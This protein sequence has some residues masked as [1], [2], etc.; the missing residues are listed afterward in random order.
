LGSLGGVPLRKANISLNRQ[1]SGPLAPGTRTNYSVSTDPSGRFAFTGIEPGTYRLSASHTGYLDTSYNARRPGGN[2]TPLDL[3]KAQRMTNVILKLTPQGL[4][5]GK[6]TDEDGDPLENVQVEVL[7]YTY[8]TGRK[9]LQ[10]VGSESTNDAGE[11]RISRLNPDKYF[12]CAVYRNRR[13][14]Q[15][16]GDQPQEDYATTYYPGGGDIATASPVEV[17]PGDQIQGMTMRLTKNRMVR[18]RGRAV[19]NTVAPSRPQANAPTPSPAAPAS[20]EELG[21]RMAE[22]G[23]AMADVGAQMGGSDV[24]VRLVPR[25]S[26]IANQQN[27]NAAVKADGTFEFGS[28]PSGSYDLIAISN[29][30]NRGRAAKQQLDVGSSNIEGINISINPGPSV[31]GRIH[32]EGDTPPDSLPKMTVRFTSRE[33]VSGIQAVP[34]ATVAAD[35]T[36]RLDDVNPDHYSVAINAPQGYYVKSMRAGNVDVLVSGMDLSAGAGNLVI[37][38]GSNPPQVGGSVVNSDAAQ[39]APAVTV[40]LIP[41][42]KER[43]GQ[44]YFYSSTTSDQYGNFTF[45]RVSPGEYRAFAWEDVTSG[46]WYDPEFMKNYDGK[47]EPVSAKEAS[48]VTLKLTMIP[49][50]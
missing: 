11:F 32:F 39:P 22:L 49:A 8:N 37:E 16:A 10:R 7:R 46:S 31:A 30:G 20:Q 42:E 43:Q 2:G 27:L 14:A 28:V 34:P 44:S 17:G 41:Q 29:R 35:G 24:Q 6:I 4:I 36:F 18:V 38:F 50:K 12:L 9:Q 1:N 19:N 48:P 47:G 40:V 21:A 26:L 45:N 3:S 25:S 33:P 23:A 15:F 5:S 13:P